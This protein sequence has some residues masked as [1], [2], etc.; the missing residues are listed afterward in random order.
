[1]QNRYLRVSRSGKSN[2]S[3]LRKS[4]DAKMAEP[5][6]AKRKCRGGASVWRA[7]SHYLE[8][9]DLRPRAL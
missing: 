9:I 6:T 4:L 5:G 3:V 7:S 2:R 8:V 1:V